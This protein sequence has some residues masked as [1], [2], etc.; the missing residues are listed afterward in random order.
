M[1][2]FWPWAL[3]L[4]GAAVL[5]YYFRDR[6]A[7]VAGDVIGTVEEAVH[8]MMTPKYAGAASPY[9]DLINLY[10]A[11][12]SLDPMLVRAII[13]QESNWNPSVMGFDGLSVG[14]M[15]ITLPVA[16]DYFG[17]PSNFTEL[18]DPETSIA[19]GTKLLGSL[20][21]R[22]GLEGAIASYNEGPGNWLKGRRDAVYVDSV[23]AFYKQYQDAQA[24]DVTGDGK[25]SA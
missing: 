3:L 14:L 13:R 16:Q 4:G 17:R 18:A 2:K 10:A 6:A 9:D 19:I 20:L 23:M 22:Y 11:K 15:Q 24:I 5:I 12:N 7:Q 1:K 21:K 8:N 25:E